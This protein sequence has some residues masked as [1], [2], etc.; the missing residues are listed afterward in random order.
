MLVEQIDIGVPIH[1]PFLQIYSLHLCILAH[2]QF[3]S[4]FLGM[5]TWVK[6]GHAYIGER[7]KK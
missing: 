4:L 7:Y 5:E 1:I 2:I 3:L 6:C